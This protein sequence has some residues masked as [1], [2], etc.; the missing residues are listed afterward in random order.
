MTTVL[1]LL[2]LPGLI[3]AVIRLGGWERGPLVQL[4]AFTP[5]VA[6]WAWLP[7]VVALATRRW[8][9][10]AVAVVAAIGLA[11]AVAPRAFPARDRGPQQGVKLTVMT[12]NMLFGRA[13]PAAIVKLVSERDVDVLA[14]Q[15]FTT[16][17]RQ[18]LAAAG[19]GALLPYSSLA[20]EPEADGSGVYSRFPVTD[21]GARRNGGGFMQA[22]AT[23]HTPGASA[24]VVESAHPIAPYAQSILGQWRA[25][26]RA[27]PHADASGTPRILLGDFN[28]TLDHTPMRQLI[29]H[30]YRDAADATGKGLAGTWGPYDGKPLPPV[31]IDHV[32]VDERLGVREASVH[33]IPRSDHRSIVAE[34]MLPAA[35][36]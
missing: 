21:A 25:D 6:A 13:D 18:A 12:S 29:A 7:A 16:E 24:V 27:Q 1:T 22:Y 9:I 11:V 31:T 20:D 3:W 34:L 10:G 36:R 33:A 15:E 5:Y 32:L 35:A 30:G 28:S 4:F 19:L 8:T 26:L 2:V 23:V 17:G 14:V